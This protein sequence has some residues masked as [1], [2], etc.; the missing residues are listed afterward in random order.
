[1]FRCK[2]DLYKTLEFKCG[3]DFG[4]SVAAIYSFLHISFKTFHK[5]DCSNLNEASKSKLIWLDTIIICTV[6]SLLLVFTIEDICIGEISS[7][8][9]VPELSGNLIMYMNQEKLVGKEEVCR[10]FLLS[11]WEH[12]LH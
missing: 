7:S 10:S 3:S 8:E 12:S 5:F 6:D 9:N 1:M 11:A 2:R 4:T